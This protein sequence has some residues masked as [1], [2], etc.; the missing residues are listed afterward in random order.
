MNTKTELKEEESIY[1]SVQET[2]PLQDILETART[3][4]NSTAFTMLQS[5]R[6][7]VKV[8]RDLAQ[9]FDLILNSFI[10]CAEDIEYSRSEEVGTTEGWVAAI[11]AKY[12]E[13]ETQHGSDK[14]VGFL[15]TM[16][17]TYGF[18]VDKEKSAQ[19]QVRNKLTDPE[20]NGDRPLVDA[21]DYGVTV[22]DEHDEKVRLET[23]SLEANQ[24]EISYA[25]DFEALK[26]IYLEF[27]GSIWNAP[28][29]AV[30]TIKPI[31]GEL[32]ALGNQIL[33][34]REAVHADP[35]LTWRV[36][37]F[38]GY[39]YTDHA[40]LSSILDRTKAKHP[41]MTVYT[42]TNTKG[43]EAMVRGWCESNKVQCI[44]E[45]YTYT[46]NK[47]AGPFIRN[48]KILDTANLHAIILFPSKSYTTG[49]HWE[50]EAAKPERNITVWKPVTGALSK[51]RPS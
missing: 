38:G 12:H 18:A 49:G 19:D 13:Y 7:T 32:Q 30:G 14:A 47:G 17:R 5:N 8:R 11:R 42:G 37:I 25:Q 20:V 1:D 43:T 34:G 36:A 33:A 23:R 6:C 31:N 2:Y 15:A 39:E 22:D 28:Q 51:A 10:E 27:T 26:Q 29:S 40:F 4:R 41:T 21:W 35:T 45:G 3:L 46:S 50:E 48:R 16:L 24:T 9:T 44:A